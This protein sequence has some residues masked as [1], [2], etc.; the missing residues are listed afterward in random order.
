MMMTD[1]PLQVFARLFV[2]LVRTK[3]N[4]DGDDDEAYHEMNESSDSLLQKMARRKRPSRSSIANSNCR[5]WWL[6]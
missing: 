2:F 4:D 5:L 1:D 3:K 6:L